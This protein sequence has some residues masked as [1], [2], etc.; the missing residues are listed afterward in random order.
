MLPNNPSS[1][2][3]S[4]RRCRMKETYLQSPKPV[5]LVCCAADPCAKAVVGRD[6]RTRLCT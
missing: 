2:D 3:L 4:P 1:S 5:Q 6:E